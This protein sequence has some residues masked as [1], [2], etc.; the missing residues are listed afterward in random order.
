MKKRSVK[1]K[2]TKVRDE[3]EVIA[4]EFFSFLQKCRK[5]GIG[6]DETFI[7]LFQMIGSTIIEEETPLFFGVV[8]D[9]VENNAHLFPEEMTVK[10]G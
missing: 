9:I 7:I 2:K 4:T 5:Q 6:D 1:N 10:Y 3:R 8:A